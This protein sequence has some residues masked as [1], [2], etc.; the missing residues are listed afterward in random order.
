M[1]SQPRVCVGAH[2]HTTSSAKGSC[3]GT[4]RTGCFCGLWSPAP[5]VQVME[6]TL[7]QDFRNVTQVMTR[8]SLPHKIQQPCF[9]PSHF[10][11]EKTD[12]EIR[13]E[14]LAQQYEAQGGVRYLQR[15]LEP[16]E[17][18]PQAVFVKDSVMF[19]SPLIHPVASCGSD[20][21]Q[22][23]SWLVCHG[24]GL[25]TTLQGAMYCCHL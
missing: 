24:C 13:Q 18:M 6:L 21:V 4:G 1:T 11:G 7:L 8:K 22:P 12:L 5:C 15:D 19:L 23:F 2:I 20:W 14:Q 3:K 17:L 9:F 16:A 10:W 25:V